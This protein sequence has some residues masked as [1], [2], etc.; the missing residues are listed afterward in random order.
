M[1]C[2]RID[3]AP[4][5]LQIAWTRRHAP[6]RANDGADALIR[7]PPE[8]PGRA[9]DFPGLRLEL[10]GWIG[11]V[12]RPGDV[13][14]DPEDRMRLAIRLAAENVA[15]RTGGPFGAAVIERDTGRI[16]SVGV[17]IVIP[18]ACSLAH[19]EAIALALAQQA[20]QDHDLAAP[21]RPVMELICSAQPC[22]QCY[23]MIWWSGVRGLAI[24]ARGEDVRSIAGFQEGPLPPGWDGLIRH[25]PDL[26][27]VPVARDVLRE[28]ALAPLIAFRDSGQAAYNPGGA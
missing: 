15:R 14:A 5:L 12:V 17:N 27:A 4:H 13:L 2:P 26:P 25:R 20:V 7:N 10:P 23:G 6:A 18:S 9:A 16:V 24:G 28:E 19:A 1:R 21:G 22:C 3:P 8:N 11:R